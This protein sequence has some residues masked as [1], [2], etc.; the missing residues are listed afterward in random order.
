M[1]ELLPRDNYPNEQRDFRSGAEE[2]VVDI[3]N[4]DEY[5]FGK[6]GEQRKSPENATRSGENDHL[7]QSDGEKTAKK[8]E[9]DASDLSM[10]EEETDDEEEKKRE[11]TTKS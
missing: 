11:D 7:N 8:R 10:D 2:E 3:E 6:Q 9:D 5:D 4:E 1:A